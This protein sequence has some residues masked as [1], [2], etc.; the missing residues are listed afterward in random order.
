M[1]DDVD[2]NQNHNDSINHRDTVDSKENKAESK[3]LTYSDDGK[4]HLRVSAMEKDERT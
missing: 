1:V 4:D 2:E 3:L